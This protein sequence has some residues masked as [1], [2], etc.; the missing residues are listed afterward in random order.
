EAVPGACATEGGDVSAGLE[1]PVARFGPFLRGW[2]VVPFL[3]HEAEAVGRVGDDCVNGCGFHLVHGF[4]AVAVDYFC[5]FVV[6]VSVHLFSRYGLGV[7][8]YSSKST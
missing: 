8:S 5:G 3:A 1:Y 2:Q 7:S 6:V 4:D